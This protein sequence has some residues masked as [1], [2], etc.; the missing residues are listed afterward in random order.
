M[1]PQGQVPPALGVALDD[2]L[3]GLTLAISLMTGILFGLVPALRPTRLGLNGALSHGGTGAGRVPRIEP[4]K[5]VVLAEMA[6]SV[7]LVAG[8]GLFIGTLRNLAAVDTGFTR[9]NVMQIWMNVESTGIPPTQC[10]TVYDRVTD[11]V[12]AVPGVIAASLSN[13]GLMESGVTRS[14]QLQVP[15]YSFRPGESD[16]LREYTVGAGY[17]GAAGIPLRLGRDF[18]RRDGDG[19]PGVAILNE[20]FVC[21]YLGRLHP[22][23]VRY[24]IGR[25]PSFYEIVVRATP[26]TTTF[27]RSLSRW[28][29]IPGSSRCRHA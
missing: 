3:L 7:P 22:I 4:G 19:A 28:H 25:S 8:A 6:L 2:R 5:A 13:R 20:E 26:N 21:H 24:G 16:Q 10:R 29:I 11:Q 27:A 9:Q 14:G 15:G 18:D 1:L 23:G 12:A 17:F